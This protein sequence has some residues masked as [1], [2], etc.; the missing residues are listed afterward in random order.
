MT[1]LGWATRYNEIV[2]DFGYSK[3]NDVQSSRLLDSLLS[4]KTRITKLKKLIEN[5]VQ[6]EYTDNKGKI[7]A[8]VGLR[9]YIQEIKVQKNH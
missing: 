7:V 2:N 1:I 3:K 9:K 8:F 4:K 5:E 6:G